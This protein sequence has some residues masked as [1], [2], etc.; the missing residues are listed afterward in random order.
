MSKSSVFKLR[1]KVLNSSAER[2]LCDSEFQTEGALTLKALA[3]G[4]SGAQDQ[5]VLYRFLKKGRQVA[6][7]EAGEE[8]Y[9]FISSTYCEQILHVT[10]SNSFFRYS[11]RPTVSGKMLHLARAFTFSSWI[12]ALHASI[13]ITAAGTLRRPVGTLTRSAGTPYRLVSA[14]FYHW[15]IQGK[16]VDISQTK[17]FLPTV[18][19][20]THNWAW[21]AS[22][23]RSYMVPI[24]R[25]GNQCVYADR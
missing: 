1:L 10:V 12:C 20:L 21:P 25:C 11:D 7:H 9:T 16:F 4:K 3:R 22:H 8:S 5:A 13:L 2:Q 23:D 17:L 15:A 6:K 19:K 24:W 18:A 14:H